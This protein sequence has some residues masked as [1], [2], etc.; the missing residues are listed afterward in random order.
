MVRLLRRSGVEL[1]ARTLLSARTV[2]FGEFSLL[3]GFAQRF[4]IDRQFLGSCL[5]GV[6]LVEQLL[7]LLNDLAGHHGRPTSATRLIERF[8]SLLAI[9]LDRSLDADGRD[10]KGLDEVHLFAVAIA[11]E[12]CS[13]HPERVAIIACMRKDREDAREVGPPVVFIDDTH[14]I[15]DACSP[16]RDEW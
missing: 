13:E 11:N 9:L 12:L 3:D 6:S 8:A 16:I 4:D 5:S 10:A 14:V 15:A 7:G 2:T 1:F